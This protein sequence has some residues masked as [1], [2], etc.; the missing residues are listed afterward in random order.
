MRLSLQRIVA[1]AVKEV[2]QLLRDRITFGMIVGI[3][4]LQITLFGYAINLDVRH[5]DAGVADL[6]DTQV[7]RQ[8]LADTQATQVVKIVHRARTAAELE[9]FLRRGEITVGIYIPADFSRRIRDP[10]RTAAQL[11]IDGSD[12]S[13]AAIAT[14]LARMQFHLR[15]GE[16]AAS[17]A[18][19]EIRN[20]YNPER[21][22]AVQIVPGLIGVILTMTMVLFTSVA[23]VRERERGNL[24]LLITTPVRNLELMIGK[25]APYIVIGLIQVSLILI[26]GVLLFQVPIVGSLVDLY[27]A[28]LLFIAASLSLGLMISTFAKT[29]FQAM[30]LT[31]FVF[32]PSILLSGFM[33]PFDGMPVIAQRVAVLLPLTHFV[34]LVRGIVLRGAGLGELLPSAQALAI[35]LVVT[36][37]LAVLR[38]RKRLD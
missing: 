5:L 18:I 8:L 12:P 27:L 25:I 1:I 24:E 30:Q 7:S 13:I 2:R 29:Q 4:L 15:K 22:S 9:D 20:Y 16:P 6:A 36:M 17:A 32:L 19:Y 23:I 38:F 26:V 3:P 10:A 28:S 37:T 35:F 21:R 34:E 11:L 33:F 31:F 14:Q